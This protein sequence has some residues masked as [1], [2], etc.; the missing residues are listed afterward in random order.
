M[1]KAQDMLTQLS[2]IAQEN[3]AL[4]VELRQERLNLKEDLK[5][6]KQAQEDIRALI[7]EAVDNQKV[8]EAVEMGLNEIKRKIEELMEVKTQ[9]I[10]DKFQ[11]LGNMF[12]YGNTQGR[13]EPLEQLII[14][15][16]ADEQ[17]RAEALRVVQ[18]DLKDK[19][20]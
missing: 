16:R 3:K 12:M 6:A 15:R 18:Q 4:L 17:E 11:Q 1:T 9:Q 2:D 5:L 20:H 8:V 10:G 14:R 7:E 13:G 19:K